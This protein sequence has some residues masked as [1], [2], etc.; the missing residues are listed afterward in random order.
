MTYEEAMALSYTIRAVFETYRAQTNYNFC[1]LQGPAGPTGPTGATGA[2]GEVGPIGP[3][4]STGAAGP[5]LTNDGFSAS[6]TTLSLSS[7]G[8]LTGWSVAPPYFNNGSFNTG[9]GNYTVPTTGRYIVQATINYSASAAISV[10]LGSSVTPS[11]SIERRSPVV[12]SLIKG[13][14]PIL[15]VNVA[16]VLSLRAILGSGTITLAGEVVLDAGDVIGLF[17][18]ANGLTINLNLGGT[19]NNVIWS[20]NRIS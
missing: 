9:T 17:Y 20:M 3:T 14:F 10:N 13:L 18:N 16:L 12:T 4:G 2:Q 7:S 19:S 5:T 6:L 11:F 8:Q 15:N 1:Y